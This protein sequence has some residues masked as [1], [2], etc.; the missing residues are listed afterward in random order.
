MTQNQIDFYNSLSQDDQY[1]LKLAAVKLYDI[2]M[3]EISKL[4]VNRKISDKQIRK[5]MDIAFQKELLVVSN[6]GM[7][8]YDVSN[9]F[10]IYIFPQ[11]GDLIKKRKQDEQYPYYFESHTQ[12]HLWDFLYYLFHYEEDKFRQA[13]EKLLTYHANEVPEILNGLLELVPYRPVI[14]LIDA[15]IIFVLLSQ[16]MNDVWGKLSSL[17]DFQYFIQHLTPYLS[18]K[19]L[20]YIHY[21][22]LPLKGQMGKF[23]EIHA[24]DKN[25][26]NSDYFIEAV[27]SLTKKDISTALA[28]FA[29]GIKSQQNDYKGMQLPA[30]PHVAFF[31]LVAL[32]C[33][34]LEETTSVF[35]KIQQSLS[36]K[37]FTPFDPLFRTVAAYGLNDKHLLNEKVTDINYLIQQNNQDYTELISFLILYL[38]DKKPNAQLLSSVTKTVEKAFSSGYLVLAYEAA[39]ALD[40]WTNNEEIK[41][42]YEIMAREVGYPPIL[43]MVVRQQEW[44]KSL[45]MLLSM[46]LDKSPSNGKNE[47]NKS[48]IV[49]FLNP[50]MGSIQPVLQTRLAKGGWSKGR[51]IALKTFYEGKPEGM[52]EQDFRV[53]KCVHVVSGFWNADQYELTE[54]AIKE[55]VGHP[56]VFLDGT[57]DVPIELIAAQPI[58]QV[59]KSDKGYALSTNI[60][61]DSEDVVI[62]KE[63]NTRYKVY[64]LTSRQRQIIQIV[65]QQKIVVPELGK[66]K[67]IQLLG[68]FSKH[69]T[70]YSDL[71][72]TESERSNVKEVEADS[73]IRVQLLPFGDGLKAELFA[74]PFGTLPPYCKP[75]KGGRVLIADDHGQQLQVK[76]DLSQELAMA[77]ALMN[78]IQSLESLDISDELI[79]FDEPM[80][81]LHLL[82]ILATHQDKC[83]VE[84][85]EG[86]KYKI[87]GSV[88]FSNLNLRLKSKSNWFELQGELKVNEETVVTIQ[89][90][91]ALTAKGHDRFIELEAGQFLAL[92]DQLKRQLE[93]LRSFSVSGKDG[94]KINKFASVA[95]G[96]F[97][98][99]VNNLMADKSWKDFRKHIESVQESEMPIPTNLQAE[100]RPYQEDGFRWLARLAAW[101]GGACL[102]DDMGLGKTIQTLAVLLHR[103]SQGPALVVCPVSVLSNWVNETAR[104]APTLCVKTLTHNNREQTL[105]SL[106]SGD[107]LITSYGLLQSEE[108]ALAEILFSTVVLDEAHTIKNYATKTSKAAMQLQASFRVALTGTPIQNHLGEIWN[109][110]NFINP[111]LLGTLQHFTDMFIKPD[112]EP[113]RRHLKKL[114]TP[115]ILRRTKSAVLDELPPKTEIVKKVLLSDDEMAFYEALRRQAIINLESDDASQGTKHLKALAE[116]TRLRQACCNPALVDSAVAIPSTKLSTFLE[117][118]AELT[119]NKH[120][121]LVFS[122]FVTHLSLVRA[123]LDKQGYTYQYLD[124]STPAAEREKSVKNFQSG[125]GALF[126]ISLKAGGLGLNLTA[127]DYV[128]HLDPWWN[129]AVEDQASDRAHRIGQSR[130]V[131]IYRLVA[132]NT[133]EEKIIQ[134]H[135]TKRDL[136]DSLLEGSDQSAK[137]SMTELMSLI[138]DRE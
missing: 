127:A 53:A 89:Q 88:N 100:L 123:A 4:V 76:R 116:I 83:V 59:V 131:T 15:K 60:I 92:S 114:I 11:L 1:I 8:N 71:L 87:R 61:D 111:G 115:F 101:E 23:S 69:M 105:Q 10:L 65:N 91:L 67:L 110:F 120:R 119:E 24:A 28:D 74:K 29:K 39:F 95:L 84:W 77:N 99:E 5:C 14:S 13:E 55:L 48:R 34:P 103:A 35:L 56:Y 117:I 109:L 85:P 33:L 62:E 31:Y 136:A 52:T 129:P 16:K 58:I 18:P 138:K 94:V 9:A 79:A 27:H 20:P 7:M 25:L 73:R 121:A 132:E 80:D 102:A 36:K 51:N 57:V 54:E 46:N 86:E 112:N 19:Q 68:G 72:A 97:F 113:S 63:T 118:I 32:V 44:E 64:D 42:L 135:N 137:L 90:L 107:I 17:Y 125:E 3:F 108:K 128:I 75:G 38:V 6:S 96:D 66:E 12:Y 50:K 104:F 70:V 81:S 126:L 47:G 78:D 43:S 124:G 21:L 82:D 22:E 134:L 41:K 2:R 122:Q 40:Q 49:Y 133:I 26:L 106:E 130:P 45:G 98:E 93:E 37:I 30:V